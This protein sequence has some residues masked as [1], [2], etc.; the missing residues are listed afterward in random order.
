[1]RKHLYIAGPMRGIAE[2][3]FP[4][5]LGA[6][7]VLR[8]AGYAVFSPARHDIEVMGFDYRNLT[9]HENLKALGFDLAESLATDLTYICR[10]ADGIALLPGW[11]RSKGATA[12]R[13]TALALGKP[14]EPFSYWTHEAFRKSRRRT[15][16]IGGA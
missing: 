13:A 10:E 1:M 5:F 2:F 4:A 9:G 16:I 12:E 15:A 6:E 14:A 8:D 7:S 3:N 11:E